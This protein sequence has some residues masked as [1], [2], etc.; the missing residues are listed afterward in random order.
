[1]SSRGVQ[2]S[3]RFRVRRRLFLHLGTFKGL[4]LGKITSFWIGEASGPPRD[5]LWAFKSNDTKTLTSLK[6]LDR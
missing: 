1:L 5:P 6:L 2:R 4:R 3:I